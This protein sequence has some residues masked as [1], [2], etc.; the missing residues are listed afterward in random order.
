[1]NTTTAATVEHCTNASLASAGEARLQPG[2]AAAAAPAA[3]D[4]AGE[5][6]GMGG[7]GGSGSSAMLGAALARRMKA[8]LAARGPPDVTVT[9]QSRVVV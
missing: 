9:R 2:I 7:R 3:R 1:M 8:G 6:K 5:A 4:G